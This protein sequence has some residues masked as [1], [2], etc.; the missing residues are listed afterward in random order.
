MPQVSVSPA[1]RTA[2]LYLNIIE[3]NIIRSFIKR[4]HTLK[5]YIAYYTQVL[6]SI[7]GNPMRLA[8]TAKGHISTPPVTM[9]AAADQGEIVKP[10]IVKTARLTD[11]GDTK[12]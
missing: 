7:K 9:E 8:Q 3:R 12:R 4:V 11:Q 6:T 1:R 10:E 2:I 5:K